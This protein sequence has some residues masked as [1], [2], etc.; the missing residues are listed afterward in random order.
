MTSL[1]APGPSSAPPDL[2]TVLQQAGRR[3]SLPPAGRHALTATVLAA[4]AALAWGL[5]QLED[6][7]QAVEV[8][9][10]NK[11]KPVKLVWSREEDFTH[12]ISRP[13]S[14]T[15]FDASLD[16]SGNVTAMKARVVCGSSQKS[17]T[18][19]IVNALYNFPAKLVEYVQDTVEVPLG[20]WRSV[21][22]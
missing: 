8:A 12:D 15:K 21:G 20:S 4:H 11:G 13:A 19:G 2:R 16:L 17:S 14:L 7:R 3:Q 22:N 18:D 9:K 5:W 6:V 10:A 1:A